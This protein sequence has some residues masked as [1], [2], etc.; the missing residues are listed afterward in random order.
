MS[1]RDVLC[2]AALYCA[3]LQ[4]SSYELEHKTVLGS[5]DIKVIMKGAAHRVA[6]EVDGPYH[7]AKN[8]P[9]T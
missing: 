3:V 9:Y 5:T 6:I 2:W 7:Y 4:L 1:C 8:D